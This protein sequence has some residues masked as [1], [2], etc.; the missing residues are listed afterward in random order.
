A[1]RSIARLAAA[2]SLLL[3]R[4]PATTAEDLGGGPE[5]AEEDGHAA[6]Q[7]AR[8][9]A[10]TEEPER[11]NVEP[12]DA[13]VIVAGH[14]RPVGL[15]IRVTLRGDVIGDALADL[16][17]VLVDEVRYLALHAHDAVNEGNAGVRFGEVDD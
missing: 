13:A 6:E 12:V 8:R 11:G 14:R 2:C 5:R 4:L 9:E 17:T 15:G 10:S 16:L 3:V 1:W 7:H